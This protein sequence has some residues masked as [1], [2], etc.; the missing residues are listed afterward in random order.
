MVIRS[1]GS[2]TGSVG[3]GTVEDMVCKEAKRVLAD[4]ICRRVSLN[5][6]GESGVCGGEVEI[7][8]EPVA[9]AAPFWIIGAGH[10]G[11]AILALGLHLP[12]RFTVVDDRKDFLADLEPAQT[13]TYRPN[14]LVQHLEPNARMVILVA[15]R[16]H[17]LD[18]EYLEAIF[19]AEQAAQKQVGYLG[20]VGSRT[21]AKY[22]AKRFAANPW[23]S[24]RFR[25]VHIPVGLAL[26]AET[27][28][29]IA[30]SLLAEILAFL[31]GSPWVRNQ[32]GEAVGLYRLS[33][34]PGPTD[35]EP[36]SR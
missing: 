20:V 12:F 30:L 6:N 21:K 8:I 27:P 31:R 28:Q 23:A 17:E 22:L 29:E 13:F 16:H 25:Q 32:E 11:R 3:G 2:V 35:Q 18:G 34:M 26:G 24:E 10:V 19:G 15:S 7:F 36:G 1:D 9:V 4:G 5:L 33:H 14:E